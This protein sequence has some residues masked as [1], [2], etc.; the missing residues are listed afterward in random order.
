MAVN[1]KETLKLSVGVGTAT[2][3]VS[4]QNPDKHVFF[5]HILYAFMS[6]GKKATAGIGM[7]TYTTY[8]LRLNL[9]H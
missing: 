9:V 4:L 5:Q 1:M 8:I 7:G 2:W 3:L 6:V